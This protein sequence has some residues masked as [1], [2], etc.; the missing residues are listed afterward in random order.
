MRLV[1]FLSY[2]AVKKRKAPSSVELSSIM[3]FTDETAVLYS[4]RGMLMCD[5]PSLYQSE[6]D[7]DNFNEDLKKLVEKFQI[8]SDHIAS[9]EY[10]LNAKGEFVY[11]SPWCEKLSGYTPEEFFNDR[12]LIMNIIH[13]NDRWLLRQHIN[14]NSMSEETASIEFRIINRNGEVIWVNHTCQSV[15]SREGIFMGRRVSNRDITEYKVLEIKL[16]EA[17]ERWQFAL[18]GSGDGVWDWNLKTNAVFYSKQYKSMLGYD[19][20]EFINTFEEWKKRIHPEDL[21]WVMKEFERHI[22]GKTSYLSLEYRLRCKDGSYKWI[23]SRGKVITYDTDSKPIR[24]VGTQADITD[25]KKAEETVMN[26]MMENKKLLNKTIE[27]DRMKTEFFSNISHEFKT[28]LNVILGTLQLL[29]LLLKE[30]PLRKIRD[31]FERKLMLM[32]QNCYRL[33]RLINNLI[34]MTK[35]DSGYL[36]MELDNYDIIDVIK[37]ITLSIQD[38]VENK[39]ITL[40]FNSS[41]PERVIACD[42][43]KIERILLNLLSN[44]IKFTNTGGKIEINITEE[45]KMLLIAVK[46]TGIGIPAN[47]LP[48][49]FDRFAQVDK[50][51]TRNHEGSGI[52]LTIVKSLVELHHGTVSVKSAHG[53][54]SEFIVR[55]PIHVFQKEHNSVEARDNSNNNHVEK[56]SIEFS[57]IYSHGKL[58]IKDGIK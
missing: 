40:T 25:R 56:I 34:D 7:Q 20:H 51:L 46:D 35:I 23:F 57:D 19:D 38:Y 29:L 4:T 52:G 2:I 14:E 8:V 21:S 45:D 26:I 6:I 55:L 37:N 50:S 17:E 9:W 5:I 49:I 24:I 41:I 48:Y 44:A 15:Y 11:I 18:E 16:K 30:V 32:K 36:E 31:K 3:S 33:L 53:G 12:E 28:P 43:D 39:R 42:P 58:S 22:S 1:V 47:K 10:W 54:G 27:Y 13:P